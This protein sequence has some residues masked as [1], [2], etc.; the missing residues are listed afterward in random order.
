M[1]TTLKKKIVKK[2]SKVHNLGELA[3]A[4]TVDELNR[5]EEKSILL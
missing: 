5:I 4:V 2:N 3:C 1:S